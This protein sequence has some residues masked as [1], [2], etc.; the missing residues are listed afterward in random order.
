M[1]DMATDIDAMF[2]ILERDIQELQTV[3][4]KHELLKF[5]G[6]ILETEDWV[7]EIH[8]DS[9]NRFNPTGNASWVKQR[10]SY[11]VAIRRALGKVP[12]VAPVAPEQPDSETE[13][14]DIP[15]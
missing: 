15:F 1:A 3:D 14:E 6:A 11:L 2:S 9:L 4:P 5:A 7:T 10:T 8:L 13:E 12:D